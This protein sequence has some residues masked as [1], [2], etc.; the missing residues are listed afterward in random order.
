M[1]YFGGFGGGGGGAM[2]AGEDH[3]IQ[4][5]L[6][7]AFAAVPELAWDPATMALAV[8][9]IRLRSPVFSG[10]S[11]TVVG[12]GVDCGSGNTVV[13]GRGMV[14]PV[15]N[16]VVLTNGGTPPSGQD[17][18]VVG[19]PSLA[20]AQRAIS[21]G[22]TGGA[23]GANAVALGYDAQATHSRSVAIGEG[24]RSTAAHRATVGSAAKPL[25]LES[26]SHVRARGALMTSRISEPPE[27]DLADGEV[28]LWLDAF[29][30]ILR[31]T[32]KDSLGNVRRGEV[33][34]T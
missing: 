29:A 32:A 8:D 11:S 6:G 26:T 33:A 20:A 16:A 31:I 34:L 10:I 25:E 19:R 27:S 4:L 9:R 28:C 23:S 1:P 21:I 14:V 2:P 17:C 5:R 12:E 15:S 22:R 13:V 3:Q 7:S 24:A 30:G 18:I